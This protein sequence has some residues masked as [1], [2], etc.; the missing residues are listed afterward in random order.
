MTAMVSRTCR[1]VADRRNAKFKATGFFRL[2]KLDGRWWFITPEGNRLILCG[3]D[4][5][6]TN[7][8]GTSTVLARNAFGELPDRK[9][10]SE[11]YAAGDGPGTVNFLTANLKRKYGPGFEDRWLEVMR[12]RLLAWGFNG[13]GKWMK[14]PRLKVPYVWVLWPGATRRIEVRFESGYAP[15]DPF[16]PGFASAVEKGVQ[17]DL[18][19][20]KDDPW[21]IGHT[22]ENE[23]GWNGNVVKEVGLRTDGLAAKEA[24]VKFLEDRSEGDL[25][26]I[27][28]KLGTQAQAW[29]DLVKTPLDVGKLAS[30]DVADFIRLASRTYFGQ[31]REVIRRYDAN[32][33]FLGSSLTVDWRSSTEWDT[34]GAEFLDAISLDYYSSDAKWIQRF[35]SAGKPILLLEFSF[36]A[37]GRGLSGLNGFVPSQRHRGLHYR[38]YVENLAADP[39]MVGFGWFL[40][41]DSPVTG[42]PDGENFNQGLMNV[43]DQPYH[44][45]ID[46]MKKTNARLYDLH[47]GQ[48]KPVSRQELG[49]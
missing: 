20:M 30:G 24:L 15:C 16:D 28:R 19:N 2:E 32:H 13:N 6:A 49:M 17:N 31:V 10:F 37:P 21:L 18:R 44:E 36:S 29:A 43:C 27:N 41:Y 48:I 45:M 38:H 3:V 25:A 22:F 40:C 46:E 7:T 34:G 42:R 26:A 35:R 33:L 11:A 39:L 23:L 4:D 9:L 5:V 8:W 12:K 14:H 47:A 1:C